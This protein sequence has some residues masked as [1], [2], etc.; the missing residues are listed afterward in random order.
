MAQRV[1]AITVLDNML[2]DP[3]CLESFFRVCRP[4]RCLLP[5]CRVLFY[6]FVAAPGLSCCVK[7]TSTVVVGGGH[8]LSDYGSALD[9]F[10]Y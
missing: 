2:H 6:S 8:S 1:L 7:V 10:T 4:A 9:L 3:A 5:C